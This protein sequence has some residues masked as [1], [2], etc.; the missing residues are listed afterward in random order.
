MIIDMKVYS[1]HHIHETE[2]QSQELW[3]IY[4]DSQYESSDLH[5]PMH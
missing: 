4:R 3:G 1:K 5:N 2:Y